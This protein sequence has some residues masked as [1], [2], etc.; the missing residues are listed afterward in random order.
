MKTIEKL[1]EEIKR[2]VIEQQDILGQ[3]LRRWRFRERITPI[4][5]DYRRCARRASAPI[6]TSPLPSS[7]PS[8][9][10][11]I[12]EDPTPE[13]GA[14]TPP[15]ATHPERIEVINNNNPPSS[16]HMTTKPSPG[17][18]QNPIDV[19]QFQEQ[20]QFGPEVYDS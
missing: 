16:T 10:T 9:L 14:A 12:K 6:A 5:A 4:V 18:S 7:L 20:F 17:S 11:D 15:P 3:L 8:S 19:D 1:E 13:D 2:Q